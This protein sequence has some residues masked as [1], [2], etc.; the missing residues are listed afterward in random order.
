MVN[1]ASNYE[2]FIGD[3]SG[4]GRKQYFLLS[5]GIMWVIVMHRQSLRCTKVWRCKM[6][7]QTKYRPERGRHGAHREGQIPTTLLQTKRKLDPS[8]GMYR[9]LRIRGV[10]SLTSVILAGPSS[11]LQYP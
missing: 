3:L 11:F 1:N 2:L 5:P 10:F 6:G 9:G 4:T 8:S 7:P